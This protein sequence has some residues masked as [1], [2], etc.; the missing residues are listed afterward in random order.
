MY[1]GVWTAYYPLLVALCFR[2]QEI[3]GEKL[4]KTKRHV[5]P[6]KKKK[7]KKPLVF[8]RKEY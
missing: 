5:H 3:K 1:F 6:A 4:C 2:V 7:K 8:I